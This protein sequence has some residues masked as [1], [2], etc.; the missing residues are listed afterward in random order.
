MSETS[1]IRGSL[2][3]IIKELQMRKSKEKVAHSKFFPEDNQ[4]VNLQGNYWDHDNW[5]VN[6]TIGGGSREQVYLWVTDYDKNADA[7]L[8]E[9]ATAV[10]KA[11]ESII[12]FRNR[13]KVET[14][15]AK[16]AKPAKAT[17]KKKK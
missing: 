4:F 13:A 8:N 10:S 15:A 9:L 11:Q 1:P 3:N 12:K 5:E 2:K 16:V 6:V 7:F 14:A 17:P